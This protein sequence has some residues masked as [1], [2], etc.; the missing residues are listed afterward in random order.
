MRETG[1]MDVSVGTDPTLALKTRK[2]TGFYRVP[3]LRMIW[4]DVAFLHDGSIGTLEEFFDKGR[5]DPGFHGSNWSPLT[6]PHAV[7]GHP[8]GL[9]LTSPDRTALIAFLKTL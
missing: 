3:S 8:F 9:D 1:A 4:M 6:K 2:G 7:A 5:L